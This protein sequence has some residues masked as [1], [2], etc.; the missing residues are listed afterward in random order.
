ML[1]SALVFAAAAEADKIQIHLTSAGQAA[2]KKAVLA[3]FDLDSH[4]RGGAKKPDLSNQLGCKSYHPKQSDLIVIGAARS[5]WNDSAVGAFV[6]NDVQRL[7]TSHMVRLDWKRTVA[8]PKVMPCMRASITK[9]AGNDGKLVSLKK[10][11]FP[12]VALLTTELRAVLDA[13]SGSQ[14]V[15]I[16]VDVIA[17]G[18]GHTEQTL[19]VSAPKITGGPSRSFELKIARKLAGRS[20]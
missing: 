11:A 19:T 17:F 3:R 20:T 9:S 6:E 4:W 18:R 15:R 12:R 10:V 8:S 14:T 1:L 13:R 7:K 5:V 16:I 2:A